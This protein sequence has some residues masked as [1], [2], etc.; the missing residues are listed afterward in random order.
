[1]AVCL[2]NTSSAGCAAT[3]ADL[4]LLRGCKTIAECVLSPLSA[5]CIT[6]HATCRLQ[7]T[8]D[9]YIYIYIYIYITCLPGRSPPTNSFSKDAD[10]PSP[11]SMQ[12]FQLTTIILWGALHSEGGPW[13]PN[14]TPPS[15]PG[16]RPPNRPPPQPQPLAPQQQ[17][18]PT[19]LG[20]EPGAHP[21]HLDSPTQHTSR[22]CDLVGRLYHPC[23]YQP[24]TL[25]ATTS[26]PAAT[27]TPLRHLPTNPTTSLT[28]GPT[29]IHSTTTYPL[30]PPTTQHCPNTG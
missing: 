4:V 18:N 17:A 25:P 30:Y 13:P 19:L 24:S 8:T 26:N 27:G 12:N 29:Y 3:D 5:H 11:S 21:T 23:H 16:P 14:P 22:T 2:H 1:M 9:I 28:T 10:K 20:T 7:H 15:T 6:Y